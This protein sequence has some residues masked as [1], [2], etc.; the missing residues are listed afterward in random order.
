MP[1]AGS[2]IPMLGCCGSED[3]IFVAVVTSRWSRSP[4]VTMAEAYARTAQAISIAEGA[5]GNPTFGKQLVITLFQGEETER[6]LTDVSGG[7]FGLSFVEACI[8]LP[9]SSGTAPLFVAQASQS[10]LK[11]SSAHIY[12]IGESKLDSR[13]EGSGLCRSFGA[14]FDVSC[15]D[16]L[17]ASG[18]I[19]IPIL[20]PDGMFDGT[21][22]G[23][24]YATTLTR[25][26]LCNPAP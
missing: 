6:H 20:A 10:V 16:F 25:D 21:K 24:A 2:V 4:R 1:C 14:E 26:A 15:V 3:S 8:D 12:H 9:F 18:Q 11:W 19:A 23:G 7:D 13:G 5:A 22:Q 17:P